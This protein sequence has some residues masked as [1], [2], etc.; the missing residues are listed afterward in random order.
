MNKKRYLILIALVVFV[1]LAVFT[2]ANPFEKADNKN[3]NKFYEVII[4]C[5]IL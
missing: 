2:F 1:F 5:C 4:C 3:E